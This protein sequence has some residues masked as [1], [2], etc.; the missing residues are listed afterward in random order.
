MDSI[1]HKVRVHFPSHIFSEINSFNNPLRINNSVSENEEVVFLSTEQHMVKL[2]TVVD[3][4]NAILKK[5]NTDLK[6]IKHEEL[7][8][9]YIQ[10]V[11]V[12]NRVVKEIPSKKEL[13]FFAA[14]MKFNQLIDKRI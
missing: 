7:N 11:D 10:I 5:Q 3:Q 9:Y 13:D 14:F 1:N 12:D 4:A 2:E 8:E 6:F